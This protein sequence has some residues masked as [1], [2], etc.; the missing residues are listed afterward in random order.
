MGKR[1]TCEGTK[2]EHKGEAGR[3]S[4]G[5]KSKISQ[6]QSNVRMIPLPSQSNLG[7]RFSTTLTASRRNKKQGK[8][9][10][11]EGEHWNCPREMD[12]NLGNLG[13]WELRTSGT[14]DVRDLGHWD[15]GCWELRTLGTMQ[16]YHIKNRNHCNSICYNCLVRSL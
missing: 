2:C 6:K 9:S 8:T 4:E 13:T 11:R 1:E 3:V 10:G 15:L 14:Q 7:C 12:Q 5:Q 16:G